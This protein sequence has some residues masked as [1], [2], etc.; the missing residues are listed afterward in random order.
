VSNYASNTVTVIDG[1]TNTVRKT[2]PVGVTPDGL[3]VDGLTGTAY[4]ANSNSNS[5]SMITRE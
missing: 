3:A 1:A 4:I 5:V 2:V